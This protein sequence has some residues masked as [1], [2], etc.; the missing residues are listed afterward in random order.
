M[1]KLNIGYNK[2]NQLEIP[3]LV[4]CNPNKEELYTLPLAYNIKHNIRY[5]AFSELEFDYPYS[6]DAGETSQDEYELLKGKRLL[7]LKAY[8]DIND[9]EYFLIQD[10]DE[11]NDGSTGIKHVLAYTLESEMLTSRLTGFTGTYLLEELMDLVLKKIPSWS[12]DTIDSSVDS[13]YRTFDSNNSTV[14]NF[15]TE[16]IEKAYGCVAEF[17]TN[18]KTISFVSN[19]IPATESDVF[20]SFANVIKRIEFKEITEE[21]CTGLYCY[22]GGDLTIRDV[23]P[24]GGTA[25][26]DFD[27][28]KTSEWMTSGLISALTNWENATVAV[29]TS[30]ASKLTQLRN[31]IAQREDS[32]ADLSELEI[33]LAVVIENIGASLLA[34]IPVAGYLDEK[35]ELET[36]ITSKNSEISDMS[37]DIYETLSFLRKIVHSLYFTSKISFDTFLDDVTDLYDTTIELSSTWLDM[38]LQNS[39]GYTTSLLHFEGT[40]GSTTIEDEV[41][42]RFWTAIAGEID[43]AQYKFGSS[44]FLLDGGMGGIVTFG[45][46]G[47]SFGLLDFTIDCWVRVSAVDV[48]TDIFI[49]GGFQD[50]DNNTFCQ[51]YIDGTSEEC[52]VQLESMTG[53]VTTYLSSSPTAITANVWH[54]VAIERYGT[55]AKIYIDG[56]S[57]TLDDDEIGEQYIS[58]GVYLVAAGANLTTADAW[59]DEL[60]VSKGIARWTSD[61][62]PPTEPY[63]LYET[64]L[65]NDGAQISTYFTDA[66]SGLLYL[67]SALESGYATYPPTSSQLSNIDA[68]LDDIVSDLDGA[69]DGLQQFDPFNSFSLRI[70]EAQYHLNSY[71]DIIYYASNMTYAQYLELT[72]YIYE[73]TYTNQH[74]ITTDIM[75]ASEIEDQSQAL[76]DQAEDI[77]DKVSEPRYEFSGEFSNFISIETFPDIISEL[78]LGKAIYIRKDEDTVIDAVLLEVSIT[79]DK[80]T[81][82]S[83]TF[84]NSYRLDNS[85]FIYSDLLG[86]AAKTGTDAL[87]V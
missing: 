57:Q 10:V 77:L 39:G 2:F 70:L 50:E 49:L 33:R 56:T 47:F 14:Y 63:T 24:L 79:Y 4:L 41:S 62:T 52:Y 48:D 67:K 74:I 26:Y 59:M 29:Q 11:S 27:Y 21:I 9:D 81:D 68:V 43:T 65:P 13:L 61:F 18:T 5:N 54:H 60:R 16:D 12:V 23:N 44:S 31:T 66:I 46:S 8:D 58:G 32:E 19:I 84:G 34:G 1:K 6:R 7:C 53:G 78:E 22:G 51:L 85:H 35:Q 69:Y 17:N 64:V 55:T 76:Y 75:T 82:F 80:P 72:G 38:Y 40:D 25:I 45:D 36:E 28:Y 3:T 37:E 87:T 71:L 83:M 73:N 15:I 86:N 20:L 42:S 30:Y